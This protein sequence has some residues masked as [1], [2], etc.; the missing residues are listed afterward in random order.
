MPSNAELATTWLGY[1]TE[2]PAETGNE[3]RHSHEFYSSVAQAHAILAVA[4]AIEGLTRHCR[5]RGPE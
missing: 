2:D 4:D 3:I 1:A 5:T